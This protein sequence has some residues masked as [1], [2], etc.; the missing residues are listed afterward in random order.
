VGGEHF[1]VGVDFDVGAFAGFEEIVH[2]EEVVAGDEDAGAG[3]DP[4]INL[5]GS[6][7]S[8]AFDVAFVKHFHD[9]EVFAADF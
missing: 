9:A 7:L 4:F 1:A 6:G 5:C 8:E 3:V 2:V